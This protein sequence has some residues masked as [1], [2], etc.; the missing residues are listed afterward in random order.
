M[1]EAATLHNIR[2]NLFFAFLSSK[3][4]Q[5]DQCRSALMTAIR[6]GSQP[7]SRHRE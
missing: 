6:A 3:R 5:L 7:A 2:H 4:R 1:G